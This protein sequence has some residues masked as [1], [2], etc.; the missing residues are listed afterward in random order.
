LSVNQPGGNFANKLDFV[1]LERLGFGRLDVTLM[2]Q[3]SDQL[4]ETTPD[5]RIDLDQDRHADEQHQ[6]ACLDLF[7][8]RYL[9]QRLYA[10]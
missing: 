3:S 4:A 8:T 6:Q 1:E 7:H 10:V 5:A 2:Y 9:L